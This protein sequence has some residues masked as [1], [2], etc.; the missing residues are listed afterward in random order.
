MRG[1]DEV[2]DRRHHASTA[3]PALGGADPVLR[4][5]LGHA[6]VGDARVVAVAPPVEVVE[7][8]QVGLQP[9]H[10]VVGDAAVPGTRTREQRRTASASDSR[11]AR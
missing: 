9:R 7:V 10:R 5:Q 6:G 8:A 11:P 4:V 2:L 3:D 1:D